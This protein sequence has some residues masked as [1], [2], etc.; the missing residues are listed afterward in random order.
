MIVVCSLLP[1]K[2]HCS[3]T[4]QSSLLCSQENLRSHILNCLQGGGGGGGG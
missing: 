3:G 1:F 2:S 4:N